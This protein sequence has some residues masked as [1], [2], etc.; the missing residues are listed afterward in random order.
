M[1]SKPPV[2]NCVGEKCTLKAD[3]NCKISI[4]KHKCPKKSQSF[5]QTTEWSTLKFN[6]G[7]LEKHGKLVSVMDLHQQK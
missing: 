3:D 6:A 7:Y 2:V 1:C 5:I 4:C